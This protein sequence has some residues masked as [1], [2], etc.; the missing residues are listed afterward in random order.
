MSKR[1]RN[2]ELSQNIKIKRQNIFDDSFEKAA[3]VQ[4]KKKKLITPKSKCT[5]ENNY[6]Y[7]PATGNDGEILYDDD[8]EMITKEKNI[9]VNNCFL[10]GLDKE[11]TAAAVAST[12]RW[13]NENIS[14]NLP[15]YLING[16][17][18]FDPR[19]KLEMQYDDGNKRV[20][21]KEQSRRAEVESEIRQYEF[22][23][24][25][26]DGMSIIRN[27]NSRK[28]P[29]FFKTPE[30][31][32]IIETTPVSLDAACGTGTLR[33]FFRRNIT[34][35]F[36]AFRKS[37]LSSNFNNLFFSN[38]TGKDDSIR[39]IIP[40]KMS[41]F[42]KIY[43]FDDELK[44]TSTEKYG[45]LKFSQDMSSQDLQSK[46]EQLRSINVV[47]DGSNNEIIENKK[48]VIYSN[49]EMKDEI[50]KSITNDTGISLQEIIKTLGPGIYF[51]FSCSGLVYSI[52]ERQPSGEIA[53]VSFDPDLYNTKLKERGR[54]NMVIYNILMDN[55][56]ELE[57]QYKLHMDNIVQRDDEGVVFFKN[58]LPKPTSH[59]YITTSSTQYSDANRKLTEKRLGLQD[60][61]LMDIDSDDDDSDDDDSTSKLEKSDTSESSQLLG[62]KKKRKKKK[63]NATRKLLPKLRKLTKKNVRHRY[64][65]KY[66]KRK[67]RMA[68]NEGVMTESRKRRMTIKRAAVS[69]K[70]RFNVLRIYR[71]NKNPS[72]CRKITKDMR[73]MDKKYKLGKTKNICKRTIRGKSKKKNKKTRRR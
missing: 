61:E 1:K 53:R 65:L 63:K 26:A 35:N 15:V 47:I 25:L 36:N 42:N 67:R 30:G 40:P 2:T 41:A 56:E 39:L 50:F 58:R 21:R 37:F 62:G 23:D 14:S 68:I 12:R 19:L 6:V 18:S 45:I 4:K 54:L 27:D 32:F 44:S 52:Y 7:L 69:K 46:I 31:V 3:Q 5:S 38:V 34:D 51:D 70:G 66:S 43:N 10:Q 49:S 11:T 60:P 24:Q 13:L 28:G 33:R 29:N 16:H 73:Y 48:S 59:D 64:K 57:R 17:S 71:K 9:I 55:F 72:A 8:G 22:V 20:T